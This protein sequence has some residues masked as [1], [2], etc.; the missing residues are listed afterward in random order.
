[1]GVSRVGGSNRR[2]CAPQMHIMVGLFIA[3]MAMP[4]PSPAQVQGIGIVGPALRWIGERLVAAGVDVGISE[5]VK[6]ALK[7]DDCP[8]CEEQLQEIARELQQQAEAAGQAR[9]SLSAELEGVRAGLASLQALG[10]G[11]VDEA[12][13][14]YQESLRQLAMVPELRQEIENVRSEVA[15]LKVSIQEIKAVVEEMRG[16]LIKSENDS[17][18]LRNLIVELTARINA[19]RD[20]GGGNSGTSVRPSQQRPPPPQVLRPTNPPLLTYRALPVPMWPGAWS[21]PRPSRGCVYR[22]M[23]VRGFAGRPY[24]AAICTPM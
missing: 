21:Y 7:L 14:A 11:H 13:R 6:K 9:G 1:M 19:N 16:R 8:H 4:V 17:K 3:C 24:L 20:S 2:S 23:W 18:E 15:A 10:Q 22:R 12:A 5:V